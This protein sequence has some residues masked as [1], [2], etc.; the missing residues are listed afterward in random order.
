M[1][2]LISA[3]S[4]FTSPTGICRHAANLCRALADRPEVDR[5]TFVA[6][7]WQDYYHDL[8]DSAGTGKTEFVRIE[9]RNGSISRNRWF[10]SGLPAI[11][12]SRDA[13]IV[14]L[15]FPVPLRRTG[16][17]RTVVTLHD[18][19][20]YD[21]PQVFGRQVFFNRLFLRSC[22]NRVDGIASVSHVTQ[23]RLHALFPAQV[24]Q[25]SR[26]IPNI[27]CLNGTTLPAP[28]NHWPERPFVL[29]VAQHRRNKNLGLAVQGFAEL[30]KRGIVPPETRLVMVGSTGPET[31]S[32]RSIIRTSG[33]E[34]NTTLLSHV[35]EAQLE[36]MYLNSLLLLITSTVE[37]FC[38]P[39]AEGLR[40]SCRPVCSDIP[41]L[42]EVGGDQCQYFSL[43]DS[44]IDSLVA[45]ARRA[46]SRPRSEAPDLERFSSQRVG[47]AYVNFYVELLNVF[48]I[49]KTIDDRREISSLIG[50]S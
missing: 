5:I 41:I 23:A 49:P 48:P 42:R 13:D 4:R 26:V 22:L 31:E 6:G 24:T 16:T 40:F 35:P 15:S 20:P 47:A 7:S 25:K 11:A 17:F 50:K 36:W 45:A 30:R 9:L 2:V 27:A 33:I 19:Y 44:P 12:R 18:L 32:L 21:C 34:H 46:L 43:V 10:V 38:L 39:L 8:L 1:H 37:G 28:P 14:H 29:V 3:L